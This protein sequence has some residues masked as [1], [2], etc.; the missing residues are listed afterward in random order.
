[1]TW[2]QDLKQVY[3]V[4]QSVV[5]KKEEIKLRD[6][7]SKYIS[8]LPLS[9]VTVQTGI[10]VLLDPEGHFKSAR[11]LEDKEEKT[12]L[13]PTT[14]EAAN[15]SGAKIAPYPLH[16][17]LK[18]V[19][20][21]YRKWSDPEKQRIRGAKESN[22]MYLE[23]LK[24]LTKVR[25]EFEV[26][27]KYLSEQDLLSDLVKAGIFGEVTDIIPS[28]YPGKDK[29]PIYRAVSGDVLGSFVRF[30]IADGKEPLWERTEVIQAWIEYYAQ[31]LATLED[32]KGLDYAEGRSDTVLATLQPKGI[33]Y[34][35]DSAKLIS[36]NDKKNFTFKGRFK[37]S[38]EAA[39][40]SYEASQKAHLALKWL[41]ERQGFTIDGRVFLFWGKLEEKSPVVATKRRPVRRNARKVGP[42]TGKY[43]A[44]AYVEAQMQGKSFRD[45]A[46]NVY[47]MQLDAATPG[48]M[49]IV[50]Y[51][52]LG[53]KDYQQKLQ[54]WYERLEI[55]DNIHGQVEYVVPSI[56]Q[57]ALKAQG[58]HG[59][60]V[61]IKNTVSDLVFCMLSGQNIPR[62]ITSKL[63]MY[64][65]R[66]NSFETP[67]EWQKTVMVAASVFKAKYHKEVSAV[68]NKELTDRSY[69]FGR[70]LAV[71][72]VVEEIAL[73][74]SNIERPT[75][76]KRYTTNFAQRPESTWK[77]ISNAIQPYMAK[78]GK[79]K[80]KEYQALLDE[81]TNN[82]QLDDEAL[83][84]L[85]HPLD[86]RFLIGYHQQRSELLQSYYH[87]TEDEK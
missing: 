21:D 34:A 46:D 4:N 72:D 18:Y 29:P 58:L 15:R 59:R 43:R 52:T 17:K 63:Y 86:G 87:K 65:T 16:D 71:A 53:A 10:E 70:L 8:L 67:K 33:R 61:L 74:Q 51:Q 37:E 83:K 38:R 54:N 62:S 75:N 80:R 76:A 50:Y 60:E 13:V 41:I 28:K 57:I 45:L 35:G 25:P 27:Y 64:A 68:L 85:N 66:P 20:K 82:F 69:L 56:Y 19:A 6:G 39:G 47:I 44:E 24:N 11:V 32:N 36:A 22:Q 26:V 49:D 3:D 14:I 31:Y 42:N 77:T 78:L 7:N 9:H 12:T 23:Q 40:I 81:I 1:M 73:Q 84:R 79:Y 2:I 30:D 55:I 48:R 5:L